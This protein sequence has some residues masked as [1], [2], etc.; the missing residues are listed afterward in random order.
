MRKPSQIAVT[1]GALALGLGVGLSPASS[2]EMTQ[3]DLRWCEE[4]I[5]AGNL[6]VLTAIAN[7][8]TDP[9]SE[10]AVQCL[11]LLAQPARPPAAPPLDGNDFDA[12]QVQ[13]PY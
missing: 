7:D 5:E 2:Q 3:A 10:L 4:L 1:L 13:V 9:R 12:Q 6:D 11:L 8:P